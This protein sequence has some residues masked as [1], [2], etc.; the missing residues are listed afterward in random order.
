M[1]DFAR[2]TS[3]ALTLAFAAVFVMLPHGQVSSAQA[4]VSGYD[5]RF[6]DGETHRFTAGAFGARPA[7]ALK[8]DIRDVNAAKQSARLGQ[9]DE[10]REVRY[11]PALDASHFIEVTVAGFL[12]ITTIYAGGDDAVERPAVHSRHV[13]IVGQPVVAQYRGTCKAL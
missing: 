7:E 1:F 8:F 10:R 13:G 11:V 6:S 9:S 3:M 2:T 4:A 12:N 5:C